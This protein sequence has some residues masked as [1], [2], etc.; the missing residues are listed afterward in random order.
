LLDEDPKLEV[1]RFL[2]EDP[3]LEVEREDLE[4][5]TEPD[6]DLRLARMAIGSGKDDWRQLEPLKGVSPI[7][8]MVAK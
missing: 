2:D 4:R 7:A 8:I 5:P 3:K 1:E 6:D